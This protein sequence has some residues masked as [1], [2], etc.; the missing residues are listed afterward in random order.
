MTNII[1]LFG[2]IL[3]RTQIVSWELLFHKSKMG[4]LIKQAVEEDGCIYVQICIYLY[5]D[6]YIYI[7]IYIYIYTN[8][9]I[10]TYID[11]YI[12]IYYSIFLHFIGHMFRRLRIYIY[13]YLGLQ[14]I[15]NFWSTPNVLLFLDANSKSR[16]FGRYLQKPVV[17]FMPSTATLN[18]LSLL[19]P[20]H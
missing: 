18:F 12:Y 15:N 7:L 6:L 4:T 3:S 14:K 10:Y 8:V 19:D 9:Y 11:I 20:L 1:F 13:I 2:S 17:N 5:T 16:R